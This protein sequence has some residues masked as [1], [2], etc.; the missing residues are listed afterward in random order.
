MKQRLKLLNIAKPKNF[1]V[2]VEEKT[3]RLLNNPMKYE[4]FVLVLPYTFRLLYNQFT[5]MEG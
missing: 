1:R 5:L 2:I 4:T 3:V